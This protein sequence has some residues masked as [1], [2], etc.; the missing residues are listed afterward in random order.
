MRAQATS[1]LAVAPRG[2]LAVGVAACGSDDSS[3]A[4]SS[5]SSSGSSTA[6]RRHHQRRRRRRSRRRSTSEWAARLKEK[7]GLTVNYQG[8]GSGAGVAQFTAGTVDFGATDPALSDEELAAASRRATRVHDPDRASARSRSPT[9]STGVEEGPQARRRD[10]R[11][12]LPR[13]GHEVERPGDRQAELGRRSCR[14]RTSRSCHRSDESGTTK[15]FTD[16][17]RRLLA[18]VEGRSASTR[19]SSG[20]PAPAPRATTASPPRSS[21][22]TASIGYVEQAYALQNNF[23]FADVK[24]KAGKYIAPTLESTSAAGEGLTI[25]TDLRFSTI[26]AA[27]RRRPT[28]SPRGRSCSSTRTCARPGMTEDKAPARSRASWT[29]RSATARAVAKELQY[30]PLPAAILEQ[31]QGEGRRP[32]VQRRARSSS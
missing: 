22:P 27:G 32:D 12:H 25:P 15:G 30:A 17:P 18:R 5:G 24:N 11:R 10:D 2:A 13:Q 3:A 1:L 7:Q 26:D 23:T 9:T 8:I 21:R 16:V 20:R 28:R 14:A 4:G 6:A 29:T 19:P 31:G